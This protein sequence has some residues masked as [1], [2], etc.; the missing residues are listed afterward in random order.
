MREQY[1]IGLGKN[2]LG[3]AI[4]GAVV[5]NGWVLVTLT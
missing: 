2:K 4:T 5:L 1:Q 3:L